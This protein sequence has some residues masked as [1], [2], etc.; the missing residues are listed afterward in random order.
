MLPIV[1]MRTI[2]IHEYMHL[3]HA[4]LWKTVR[5]DLPP[6]LKASSEALAVEGSDPAP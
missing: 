2:L 4:I 3:D 6:L 1:G 5:E